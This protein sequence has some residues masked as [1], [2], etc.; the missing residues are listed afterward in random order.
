LRWFWAGW[1]VSPKIAAAAW[2]LLMLLRIDSKSQHRGTLLLAGVSV[3]I[4]FL[5]RPELLLLL[6]LGLIYLFFKCPVRTRLKGFA[7]Y[8]TGF[9]VVTV[10][11]MLY[12]YY[13]FGWIIPHTIFAKSGQP[14]TAEYLLRFFKILIIACL[15]FFVATMVILCQQW[16]IHLKLKILLSAKDKQEELINF[17]LILIFASGVVGYVLAGSF[18]EQNKLSLFTPFMIM[19]LGVLM[20]WTLRGD[21]EGMGLST[22]CLLI[23]SIILFSLLI[24]VK[25]MYRYS[26]FNPRFRQGADI[27]FIAF[28][29]K[30]KEMTLP[31]DKIGLTELGVV[32]YYTDRYIIDFVGLAT[33]EIIKYK[34]KYP[35]AKPKILAS[36][37]KIPPEYINEFLKDRGSTPEYIIYNIPMGNSFLEGKNALLFFDCEYTPVYSKKVQR[38]FMRN[39]PI[40]F[41]YLFVL[42]KRTD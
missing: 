3:G 5:T 24:Q 8:L 30:V 13:T 37:I 36:G 2:G 19:S 11:W 7:L 28:A 22:A 34:R 39:E 26:F 1:E 16:P 10:P 14:L 23:V 15:P 4:A 31:S 6:I 35:H 40:G 17:F 12:A 20:D 42:Y 41:Y 21:R 32:G 27:E 9:L 25:L 38:V 33:P 29:K 18:I